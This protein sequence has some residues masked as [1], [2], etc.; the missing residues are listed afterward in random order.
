MSQDKY[1]CPKCGVITNKDI[2]G[3]EY[4][5]G[6]PECYDGISEWR[7]DKCNTRWGRWSKKILIGDEYEKRFGGE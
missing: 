6:H 3:I 1:V 5:Y 7:C 4:A 2:I